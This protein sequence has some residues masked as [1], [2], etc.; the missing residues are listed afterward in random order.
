MPHEFINWADFQNKLCCCLGGDVTPGPGAGDG[1]GSGSGSALVGLD[2]Q[3]DAEV[4]H[5]SGSTGCTSASVGTY[6]YV[7]G[8]FESGENVG[9]FAA[10]SFV[11]LSVTLS[12]KPGGCPCNQPA[13]P[14]MAQLDFFTALGSL[15]IFKASSGP[16]AGWLARW[17][18]LT[19]LWTF[20]HLE[21]SAC[22]TD[23]E[24]TAF[25]N[26][27]EAFSTSAAT[28]WFDGGGLCGSTSDTYTIDE[29][30]NDT[31]YGDAC[32]LYTWTFNGGFNDNYLNVWY[33]PV[34]H[35]WCAM[36][37]FDQP[38]WGGTDC[39]GVGGSVAAQIEITTSGSGQLNGTF[40][41]D[42]VTTVCASSI[43]VV[44]GSG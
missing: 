43:Q 9:D 6:T 18:Y 19:H 13:N 40:T 35:E 44:L 27:F 1:G 30:S 36:V 2:S 12:A 16:F 32:G 39:M 38:A 34:A 22:G 24:T 42:D 31:L 29:V 33:C 15:I 28:S 41:L 21:D 25:Y 7:D 10:D 17:D 20:A 26:D 11:K 37:D 14:L 5:F 3:P 4:T 8:D 23:T